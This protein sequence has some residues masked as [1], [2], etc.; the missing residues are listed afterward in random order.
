MAHNPHFIVLLK[1]FWKNTT[2]EEILQDPSLRDSISKE[3]LIPIK[4]V[5]QNGSKFLTK[6]TITTENTLLTSL[7]HYSDVFNASFFDISSIYTR[8]KMERKAH[9]IF[10]YIAIE[11]LSITTGKYKLSKSSKKENEIS[12][13][14]NLFSPL[15][16]SKLL[17]YLPSEVI[18][19]LLNQM[20]NTLEAFPELHTRKI[21]QSGPDYLT[22]NNL[23]FV[24]STTKWLF[25]AYKKLTDE[26]GVLQQSTLDNFLIILWKLSRYIPDGLCYYF[27]ISSLLNQPNSIPNPSI[28]PILHYLSYVSKI[29]SVPPDYFPYGFHLHDTG[30]EEGFF[31]VSFLLN[32]FFTF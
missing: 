10:S 14:F 20:T 30:V 22:T 24:Q 31:I 12:F 3:K 2:I 23:K 25:D 4:L 29:Q 8:G 32:F 6:S 18:E 11:K 5:H 7:K 21:I 16:S 15:L 1:R 13:L 26:K 27:I 19:D 28:I 17:E 9:Q